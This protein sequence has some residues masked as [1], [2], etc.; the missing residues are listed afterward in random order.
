MTLD[1]TYA[2]HPENI[3]RVAAHYIRSGYE[4]ESCSKCMKLTKFNCPIGVKA[5][6]GPSLSSEMW[7]QCKPRSIIN[8][9]G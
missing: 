5:I 7:C 9:E 4:V 3:R 8:L 6:D 2:C 1:T